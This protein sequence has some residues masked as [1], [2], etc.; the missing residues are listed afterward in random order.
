M[1]PRIDAMRSWSSPP[2][3]FGGCRAERMGRR[4]ESWSEYPGQRTFLRRAM[5][6]PNSP[7]I[8]SKMDIELVAGTA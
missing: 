7:D 5:A 1:S 4:C 2:R 8:V 6:S 3:N